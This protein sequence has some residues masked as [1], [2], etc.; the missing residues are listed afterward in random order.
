VLTLVAVKL[1]GLPA[2]LLKLMRLV[3]LPGYQRRCLPLAAG[4]DKVAFWS[5]SE[6]PA[7]ALRVNALKQGSRFLCPKATVNDAVLAAL[8]AGIHQVLGPGAARELVA[9]V[10]VNVRPYLA[11]FQPK[12]MD[13]DLPIPD[14]MRSLQGNQIG[15]LVVTLPLLDMGRVRDL[16]RQVR[17]RMQWC[18]S[19]P[20]A[21]VSFALAYLASWL[22]MSISVA[23]M[24]QITRQGDVAVSN[25]Q[26][27]AYPIHL[28]G[29]RVSRIVG[30]LPPPPGVPLGVAVTSYCGNLQVSM[31]CDKASLGRNAEEIFRETMK[32]LLEIQQ[33]GAHVSVETVAM[34]STTT[35]S[36][37]GTTSLPGAPSAA[38]GTTTATSVIQ[39]AK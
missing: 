10:P 23:A 28:D 33:A 7:G 20:E 35:S 18:K 34:P 2:E 29:L 39:V 27:P 25:V 9:L 16:M 21:E 15:S 1:A 36:T 4:E 14:R 37:A 8:C 17:S 11:L 12:L 32:A 26:G 22:P 19:L 38:A 5:R 30:F 6:D 13:P 31:N 24:R 3:L